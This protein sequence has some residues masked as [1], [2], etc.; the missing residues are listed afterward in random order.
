VDEHVE[1]FASELDEAF[2]DNVLSKLERDIFAIARRAEGFAIAY[3]GRRYLL[4]PGTP[5]DLMF[6]Y[7]RRESEGNR[8]GKALVVPVK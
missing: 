4:S 6:L 8:I 2:P 1:L 7:A 5:A 3:K